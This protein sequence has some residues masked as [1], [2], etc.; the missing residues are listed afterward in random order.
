VIRK[1]RQEESL[2]ETDGI[3]KKRQKESQRR[4]RRSH[5]EETEGVT[6][7]ETKG[8]TAGE[9]KGVTRRDRRSH[10]EETK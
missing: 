7:G 1:K 3:T 6:A 5:K 4:D 9:T 2:G 8:V 10:K